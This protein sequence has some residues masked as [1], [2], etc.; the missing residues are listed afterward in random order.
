LASACTTGGIRGF[1]RHSNAGGYTWSQAQGSSDSLT[2]QGGIYDV[3]THTPLS[4][5]LVY[6]YCQKISADSVGRYR[7][8]VPKGLAA[9]H[10]FKAVAFGYK[11]VETTVLQP[12]SDVMRLD[13]YLE[14][15]TEPIYDCQPVTP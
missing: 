10:I 7:F 2:I 15:N 6:F 12:Q 9:A 13:F 14:A 5:G 8:Q 11:M 4:G 1:Y 3:A